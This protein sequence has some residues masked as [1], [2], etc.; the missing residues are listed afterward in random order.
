MISIIIVTYNSAA[1]IVRC[2]ERCLD[3]AAE[4]PRAGEA[5]EVIVIDN[6]SRD[7]TMELVRKFPG[8]KLIEPGSNLGFAAA[9]NLGARS[10]RGELLLFLNPDTAIR[11]GLAHLAAA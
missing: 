4:L 1:H 9:C 6:A 7:S 2:L 3:A 11:S 8:V 5:A 10:S